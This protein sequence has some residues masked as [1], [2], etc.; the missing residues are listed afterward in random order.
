MLTKDQWGFTPGKSTVTALLSSFY[1][2]LQ[3]LESGADVSFVFFDLRKAFDIVHH[4]PLLQKL[5]D[6]GLDQHILQWITCYLHGR[7]QYVVVDGASSKT[8]PVVSGVPQ[9]SC[10][11]II[12]VPC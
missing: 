11:G 9:G 4:L 7:E 3:L 8:T 12:T 10:I 1:D 6:C 2:I 5:S